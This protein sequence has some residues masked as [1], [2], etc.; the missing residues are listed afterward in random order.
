[1]YKWSSV[2]FAKKSKFHDAGGPDTVVSPNVCS[3]FVIHHYA[4]MVT[5]DVEG[6]VDR[7]K[8]VLFIDLIELMKSSKNN[9]IQKLFAA[10]KVCSM[11]GW[12]VIGDENTNN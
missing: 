11:H 7:N 1:M 9:F 6:F 2:I 8:D 10:D 12:N 3:R 4:G 5:Y